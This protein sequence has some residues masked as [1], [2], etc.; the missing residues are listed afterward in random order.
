[1]NAAFILRYLKEGHAMEKPAGINYIF[2]V[3]NQNNST[4]PFQTP[5]KRTSF[6]GTT[7]I[8]FRGLII[9]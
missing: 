9:S 6:K 8:Y 1:M 4:P 7:F 2:E 5:L 3:S